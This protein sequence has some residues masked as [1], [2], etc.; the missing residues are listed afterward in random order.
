MKSMLLAAAAVAYLA[1]PALSATP[2]QQFGKRVENGVTIYYGK[3]L[4]QPA[5]VAAETAAYR[6]VIDPS[7]RGVTFGG[8]KL[9]HRGVTVY[10]P[11]STG[12]PSMLNRLFL[13]R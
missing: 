5:P 6:M 11:V 13:Y 7:Y 1:A 12:R 2:G 3:P 10:Q 8:R 4:A 9:M